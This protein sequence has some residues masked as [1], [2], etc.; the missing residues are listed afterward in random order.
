MESAP[1]IAL[2]SGKDVLDGVGGHET[3]VRAHALAAKR[4]G[5][6]PHIFCV[7][8]RARTT[9]TDYATVHHVRAPG[10]VAAQ[11]PPLAHAAAALANGEHVLGIHG[12]ALWAAAGAMTG[13]IVARRGLR[14]AILCN[15]YATRAYEVAAMQDGLQDHHGVAN[16]IRYRAW[17]RWIQTVDN[18]VERWGY[19]NSELVLVNY[20]STERILRDAYGPDLKIRRAPYATTDAFDAA[21]PAPKQTNDPPQILCVSRH[22]PRKGIDILIQA[23]SILKNEGVP[24]EAELIGPGR[25]LEAHRRLVRDLELKSQ[26][27]LPGQVKDVRPHFHNADIYVL[28]SLAEA[29]GSVSILEALR[30]GTAIVATKIDGIPEDL[31]DGQDSLLI[32]PANPDALT[33]ALRTLI[34]NPKLR[35]TIAEGARSTHEQRFSANNFVT[36]LGETYRQLN[37]PTPALKQ[38]PPV[39]NS[40]RGRVEAQPKP[41]RGGNSQREGRTTAP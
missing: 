30:A 3:Y 34:K 25:L 40:Q 22:D 14:S 36:T 33:T 18:R 32:D 6:E 10:P 39:G 28:P 11:A 19:K 41:A 2:M 21:E 26:V 13:R 8:P 35:K 5:L 17:L 29:S 4:L 38:A 15:A 16:R 7:G 37:I 20:A 9:V 12:F 31:N 24:F 1:P 27:K 23:L